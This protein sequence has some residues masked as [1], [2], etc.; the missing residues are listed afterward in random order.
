[1]DQVNIIQKIRSIK[2][3][4][5]NMNDSLSCYEINNIKTKR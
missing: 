1:M 4:F 5:K 2:A 3:L